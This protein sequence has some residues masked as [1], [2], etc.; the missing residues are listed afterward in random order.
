MVT[1]DQVDDKKM[2]DK[3]LQ[4]IYVRTH[5]KMDLS[6]VVGFLNFASHTSEECSCCGTV[7]N[8]R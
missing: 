5:R 3:K 8:K 4:K 1:E 7:L 2:D 6:G